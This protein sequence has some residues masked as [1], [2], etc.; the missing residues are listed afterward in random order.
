[1]DLDWLDRLSEANYVRLNK[2][3]CPVLHLESCF[4]FMYDIACEEK[5]WQLGEVHSEVWKE[6]NS[7]SVSKMNKEEDLGNDRR[8]ILSLTPGKV[9]LEIISE[10]VKD[11]KGL[12]L[13]S[14]LCNV[15]ISD[16]GDGTGVYPQQ[17]DEDTKPRV[18]DG[19]YHAAVILTKLETCANRNFHEAL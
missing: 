8:V 18:A 19:P 6:E 16:L 12:I 1:M 10:L 11:L 15:F 14:A 4:D 13:G 17:F 3:E 2:A 9:I 5:S 7:I